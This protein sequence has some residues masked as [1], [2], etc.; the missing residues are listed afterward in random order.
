MNTKTLPL[1]RINEIF[2]PTFQG[3]GQTVGKIS[4]FIRVSGCNLTC[5]WCDTPY[6]WDWKGQNGV[7]Y[8]PKEETL[9]LTVEQV[10]GQ[11]MKL[12]MPF[13]SHIVFT[14]GEPMSQQSKL[15][16]VMKNL[17]KKGFVIEIETNGTILAKNDEFFD[18]VDY[19]NISPKLS[20][21]GMPKEKTIK[22][23]VLEQYMNYS[24]NYA[25]KFVVKEI[26]DLFEVDEIVEEN[27]LKNIYIMPEG[28][29]NKDHFINMVQLADEILKRGYN[30]S[31]RLHV[32]LWS[33]ERGK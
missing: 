29:N 8:N 12:E 32:L 26:D 4:A 14:G 28:K 9:G 22:P 11:I 5:S 6:T 1:V 2:G 18:Y 7:K 30:L 16:H 25:F 33:D 13:G 27:D 19:F 10:I 31:P 17:S 15:L 23:R 21:A 20:N 3:E 24:Q